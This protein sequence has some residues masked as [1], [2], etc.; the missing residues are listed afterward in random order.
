[1]T[2]AF[3]RI[4]KDVKEFYFGRFDVRFSSIDD[5][6]KGQGFKIVEINGAGAEATHIWDRKT[7]LPEAYGALMQ[8]Y[9]AMWEIGAENAKRGYK[10]ASIPDL[11]AAYRHE[12]NLWAEYPLTE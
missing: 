12:A 7:T 10:P 1:M 5:L 3:D 11:W 8:Q 4:A 6:Q 9:S 2:D